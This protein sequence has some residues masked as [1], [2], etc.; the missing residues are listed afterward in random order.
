MQPEVSH[1]DAGTALSS[2]FND[3]STTHMAYGYCL[4]G[5]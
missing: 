1:P 2:I 3:L 5:V 4:Y